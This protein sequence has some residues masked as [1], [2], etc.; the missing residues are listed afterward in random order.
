[1]LGCFGFQVCT[2]TRPPGPRPV[3]PAT[4]DQTTDLLAAVPPANGGDPLAAGTLL[5]PLELP[6]GRLHPR[7]LE[8]CHCAA[9]ERGPELGVEA[10]A[11]AA[12]PS[13]LIRLR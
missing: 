12:D 9:G 7:V 8:P 3:R 4:E 13:Q 11:V 10:A 6:H 2:S 1:M 5:E